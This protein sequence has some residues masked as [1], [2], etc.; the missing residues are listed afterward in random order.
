MADAQVQLFQ[1]LNAHRSE[2]EI[3][4]DVAWDCDLEERIEATRQLL[5]WLEQALETPAFRQ[6]QPEAAGLRRPT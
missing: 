2:L 6:A 4:R 1:A 3:E 5:E